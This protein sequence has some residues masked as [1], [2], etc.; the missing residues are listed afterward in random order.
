LKKTRTGK[1]L[2]A[3]GDVVGVVAT[4]F[5][6]DPRFL[7]TG[8]RWLQQAGYEVRS[9]TTVSGLHGYFPAS[10][11]DR[12]ADFMA[13]VHDRSIQAIWFARGGYGS[14]RILEHVDWAAVR[15]SGKLFI[16]Y[17]DITALALAS[18][19]GRSPLWMYGPVVTELGAPDCC[20]MAGFRRLLRGEPD[21]VRF[22]SHQVVVPGRARGMLLGGNLSVLVHLLGTPYM[23]SLRRA[24]L[25]LEDVGEETY[26]LDRLLTHL[27]MSGAL[28]NVAGICLGQFNPPASTRKY[29][30]DRPFQE[31][32]QEILGSLNLP[33]VQGL[34]FGHIDRKRVLPLGGLA[35]LNTA[36]R[37]LEMIPEPFL[38][39]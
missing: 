15:R 9:G 2:L 36:N 6:P 25:V 29:P 13:M 21:T 37:T 32:V 3:R 28:A 33:V 14:A 7:E 10:D 16:G 11:L 38:E 30:G 34:P 4:G 20:H 27:K 1:Q 31:A 12:A 23:P 35:V 24:I 18:F 39:A 22:R 26:R 8:V 5:A 19:R 17:S